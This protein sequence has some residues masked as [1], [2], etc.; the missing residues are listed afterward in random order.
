MPQSS[1]DQWIGPGPIRTRKLNLFKVWT[2]G[3]R[4]ID[5]F[6]GDFL[7]GKELFG[8][9]K[10][11][12]KFSKNGAWYYFQPPCKSREEQFGRCQVG[13]EL[14]WDNFTPSR[15]SW[16]KLLLFALEHLLAPVQVEEKRSVGP[17]L[18]EDSIRASSIALV[19]GFVA[20]VIFMVLYYGMAGVIANVA[21]IANLFLIL[22][23]MSLFEATLTLPGMAG[24]VLNCWYGSRCQCYYPWED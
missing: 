12:N 10:W 9:E 23:I 20:V 8:K 11:P 4:C 2:W 15:G 21:L 3:R 17:S 1:R 16:Y 14:F 22:A 13:P 5:R 7:A 19:L 6:W 18:G 24:I